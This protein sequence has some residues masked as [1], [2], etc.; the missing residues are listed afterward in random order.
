METK[1]PEG[2]PCSRSQSMLTVPNQHLELA[3]NQGH[4]VVALWLNS[5]VKAH[6]IRHSDLDSHHSDLEPAVTQLANTFV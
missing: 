5:N 3:L 2:M 6:Q 1:A 4:H